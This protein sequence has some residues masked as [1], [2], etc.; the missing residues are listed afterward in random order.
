MS[1][2]PKKRG[3]FNE[4]AE[5]FFNDLRTFGTQV[6][7]HTSHLDKTT[8]SQIANE[9]ANR[10]AQ[11][12]GGSMFY[13]TKHNTWQYHERDLAIWQ[14]FNGTNHHEL[15]QRFNLSVPY[16]YEILARV[17]KNHASNQKDLFD[18]FD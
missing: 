8:A 6:I 16:I 5:N 18:D 11:H 15:G 13:V 7:T 4:Q 1:N 10:L 3:K 2:T 17:R 14:A 12:W 9:L